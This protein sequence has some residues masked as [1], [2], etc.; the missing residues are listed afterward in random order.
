M[1]RVWTM[2]KWTNEKLL[3]DAWKDIPGGQVPISCRSLEAL[4]EAAE[5]GENPGKEKP[6]SVVDKIWKEMQS[7]RMKKDPCSAKCAS[8]LSEALAEAVVWINKLWDQGGWLQV[9]PS[10]EQKTHEEK[11]TN[12][13]AILRGQ[14]THSIPMPKGD[15]ND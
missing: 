1:G 13:L 10:L 9:D 11:L 5:K 4:I 15:Q 2:G 6:K 3:L 14:K 12:I 7:H 8:I